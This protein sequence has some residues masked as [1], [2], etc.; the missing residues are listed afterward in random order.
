MKIGT[1]DV[2]IG[3]MVYFLCIYLFFF[4]CSLLVYIFYLH[5]IRSYSKNGEA[6]IQWSNMIYFGHS[7]EFSKKP[8]YK[9]LQELKTKQRNTTKKIENILGLLIGG[10]RFFFV[11]DPLCLEI[12]YQK[13][14][15]LSISDPFHDSILLNFFNMNPNFIQNKIIDFHLLKK[16]NDKYLL[17]DQLSIDHYVQLSFMKIKIE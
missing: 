17:Q 2:S 12:F 3:T 13:N 16:C 1:R 15:N 10:Q 5:V 11:L 8:L 4:L 6:P 9:L 7:F 14:S